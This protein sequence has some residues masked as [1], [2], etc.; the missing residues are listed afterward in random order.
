MANE[1]NRTD[2]PYSGPQRD[3]QSDVTDETTRSG[4]GEDVRGV[5]DEGDEDFEDLDEIED[6]DEESM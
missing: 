2:E 4:A 3:R 1:R 6:E 5:A